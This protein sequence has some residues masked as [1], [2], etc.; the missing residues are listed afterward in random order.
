M[1][2][3]N[4]RSWPFFMMVRQTLHSHTYMH[5]C[6]HYLFNHHDHNIPHTIVRVIS[7]D[8][9]PS[10]ITTV[11]SWSEPLLVPPAGA[12]LGPSD[13]RPW[14]T[15][16]TSWRIHNSRVNKL[17]APRLWLRGA[18]PSSN[19][20]RLLVDCLGKTRCHDYISAKHHAHIVFRFAFDPAK[21][22]AREAEQL[23]IPRFATCSEGILHGPKQHPSAL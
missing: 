7:T 9:S 2:L 20:S 4:C 13:I 12:W 3:T 16:G 14:I 15:L 18:S 5:A 19:S 6:G 23:F 17:L 11:L 22:L 8:M 21:Q 10:S 1:Y